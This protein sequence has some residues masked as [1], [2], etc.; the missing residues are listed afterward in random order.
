MP[1]S[2]KLNVIGFRVDLIISV[3]NIDRRRNKYFVAIKSTIAVSAIWLGHQTQQ[4][5]HAYVQ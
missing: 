5:M 4:R 2:H 1:I 3:F